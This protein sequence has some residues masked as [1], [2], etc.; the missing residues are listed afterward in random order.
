MDEVM[1]YRIIEL[2]ERVASN[3]DATNWAELGLLTGQSNIIDGHSRLLR[4]LGFG[5]EDYS[6]NVLDVLKKWFRD[7]RIL[8]Q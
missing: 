1:G 4:S 3:F 7:S 8:W 2:R 5:D 6:G